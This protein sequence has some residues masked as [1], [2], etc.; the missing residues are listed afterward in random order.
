MNFKESET[1]IHAA[2]QH[3]KIENDTNEEQRVLLRNLLEIDLD[4]II[5]LK[6][7]NKMTDYDESVDVLCD[8]LK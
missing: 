6:S 3:L 5:P 2:F 4:I 8:I 7:M 1:A